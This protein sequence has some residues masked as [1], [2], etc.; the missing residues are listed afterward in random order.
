[1]GI[2]KSKDVEISKNVQV[3]IQKE[4]SSQDEEDVHI[5]SQPDESPSLQKNI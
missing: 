2:E 3:L 5:I 1:M 4:S